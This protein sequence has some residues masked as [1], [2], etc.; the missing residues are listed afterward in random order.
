MFLLKTI[1]DLERDGDKGYKINMVRKEDKII[2]LTI[3]NKETGF[4]IIIYDSFLLLPASLNKLAKSFG[5]NCKLNFDVLS[6]D[7]ADLTNIEFIN[8][9]LEYNRYDCKLLYDILTK[10]QSEIANLFRVSIKNVPTLPSLA[11][12][13]FRTNFMK[14]SKIAITSLEDYREISKGYRGGAV[15]VYKPEGENLFYYDVNSLY[16][17]VMKEFDYPVGATSYFSGKKELDNIFGIVYAKVKAPDNMNVPILLIKNR[18]TNNKTIAPLGSWEGWYVSEELKQAKSCGY[19]I[20][21]IKGCHW[22]S[23]ANISSDYVDTLYKNRL[24]YDKSDPKNFISKLLMNSLYGKL[25]MSP[26][27]TTHQILNAEDV[28]ADYWLDMLHDSSVSGYNFDMSN[29][30]DKTIITKE[31]PHNSIKQAKNQRESKIFS[32][33]LNISTP[34]AM[35]ITA[36]ARRAYATYG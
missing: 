26:V 36:Y 24:K 19:S 9:L 2:S 15:D 6:N 27:Q 1:F 17:Y 23:K 28:T 16:P 30:Q 3:L 35:F 8:N 29:L 5:L 12:K 33:T 4:K 10:F 31:I 22:N 13:I 11:F 18:Q 21:V 14:D 20:E 32:K 25:G 7:D 34:I